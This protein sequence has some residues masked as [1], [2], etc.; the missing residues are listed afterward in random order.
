MATKQNRVRSGEKRMAAK[1]NKY[2]NPYDFMGPVRDPMLF[3]GRHGELEEIEY[4]L[5]LSKDEKPKYSHL[6]LVGPRSAGKTSLLNIIGYTASDLGCLA[7]KI[8]LNG[9]SMQKQRSLF[10]TAAHI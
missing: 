6:A 1:Q 4:Y 2:H 9:E 8:P 3:A 7:V 10:C 5:K